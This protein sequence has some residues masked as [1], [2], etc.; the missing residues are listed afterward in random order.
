MSPST[1]IRLQRTITSSWYLSPSSNMAS[2]ICLLKSL[3]GIGLVDPFLVATV[4]LPSSF[5][6][7]HEN[8][9]FVG[10]S[11]ISSELPITQV[12]DSISIIYDDGANELVDIVNYD[13]LSIDLQKTNKQ[14]NKE[15]DY[16]K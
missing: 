12:G 8:K 5:L 3:S 11:Q 13:N 1:S 4:L 6:N 14:I 9:I 15:Q 10:S 2:S 16:K 7:G